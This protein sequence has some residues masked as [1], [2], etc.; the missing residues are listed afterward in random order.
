[1]RLLLVAS[2]RIL[3]LLGRGSYRSSRRRTAGP[4]WRSPLSVALAAVGQPSLRAANRPSA[5]P[6]A[7]ARPRAPP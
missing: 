7:L 1:M 3:G 6:W 4:G 2:A 5:M